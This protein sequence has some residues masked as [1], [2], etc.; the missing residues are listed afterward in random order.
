MNVIVTGSVAYDTLTHYAGKLSDRLPHDEAATVSVS[1]LVNDQLKQYGG[2]ATNAA[3]TLKLLGIDP[4]VVSAVGSDFGPYATYLKKLGIS[5]KY[6][7][8][9]KT[10]HTSAYYAAS[11]DGGGQVGIFYAGAM[12]KN[13]SLSLVPLVKKAPL[14][15]VTPNSP[16][17]STHMVSECQR[18]G[19]P[20]LYNPGFNTMLLTPET[21]LS[22]IKQA[23]ILI[24]NDAEFEVITNKLEMSLEEICKMVPIVVQTIG[25]KGSILYNEGKSIA[26]G[27]TKIKKFVDP[28]GAGDAYM[29]GFVAGYLRNLDLVTC[30]QIGSVAAAYTVESQGTQV[31]TFTTSEFAKRYK[32]A[33]GEKLAL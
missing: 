21:M 19:I 26:V 6:F 5:T 22:A 18:L 1:L 20:Y 16:D 24:A 28:S 14:A 3:Y 32:D 13:S 11:D 2:T 7:Q 25:S 33:F 17:A 29:A 12:G 9:E 4:L 23:K 31:H 27:I 10:L 8:V 30:C 15:L